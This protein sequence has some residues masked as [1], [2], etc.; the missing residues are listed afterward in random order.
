[1]DK[2]ACVEYIAKMEQSNNGSMSDNQIFLVPAAGLARLESGDRVI[3]RSCQ[4][5]EGTVG[6]GELQK[7]RRILQAGIGDLPMEA[8]PKTD[9]F[10]TLRDVPE[11]VVQMTLLWMY[12]A[13]DVREARIGFP[14]ETFNQHIRYFSNSIKLGGR[15]HR[16]L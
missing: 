10:Y 6:M 11:D 2:A 5:Y 14:E 9:V 12:E 3:G 15:V 4:V 13:S 7:V 1:M 16:P 8:A